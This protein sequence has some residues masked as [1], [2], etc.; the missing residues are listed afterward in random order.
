[1]NTKY[2]AFLKLF[3]LFFYLGILQSYS[4]VVKKVEPPFWWTEMTNPELQI[5]IYGDKVSEY[6]IHINQKSFL[7]NIEKVDNLDYVFLNL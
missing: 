1:M 3:S 4:Q 7:V 2:S 5:M 6:D